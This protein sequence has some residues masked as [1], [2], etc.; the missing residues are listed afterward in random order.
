[1]LTTEMLRGVANAK[2]LAVSTEVVPD[3]A[4][5]KLQI[6]AQTELLREVVAAAHDPQLEM[7]AVSEAGDLH[8]PQ[9]AVAANED[10]A[11]DVEL[12]SGNAKGQLQLAAPTTELPRATHQEAVL[13]YVLHQL[14]P[15]VGANVENAG[16]QLPAITM[17]SGKSN[18]R[19][20]LASSGQQ[21][22][23][24]NRPRTKS[25]EHTLHYGR[26]LLCRVP[27]TPK[28]CLHSAT[29]GARHTGYRQSSLC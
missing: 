1:M 9:L 3:V 5:N 29:K 6:E 11:C 4:A 24:S 8:M 27:R 2:Q 23:R 18:M 13:V 22:C 21:L 14:A 10:T 7:L 15:K 28:P 20:T 26:S 25:N 19:T 16:S 17:R 12:H